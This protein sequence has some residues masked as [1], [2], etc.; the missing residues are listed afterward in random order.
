MGVHLGAL[1]S[2]R[3]IQQ[4]MVR[5]VC[6]VSGGT[7]GH[8]MPALVLARELRARGHDPVLMTEGREVERA[9]VERELPDMP[10]LSLP[11]TG[12]MQ[13]PS[14]LSMP[15]WVART[16]LAARRVLRNERIDCV[17]STGGR[18]SVPVGLAARSLGVPLFLLEQNAVTG[19]ANRLLSPLAKR[20]YHGLPTAEAGQRGLLTGTPLRP[21]VGRPERDQARRS[22]AFVTDAPL[23]LVVGG[24]Q[25]AQALNLV[26]PDAIVATERPTAV[27]HLAG[28]GKET[29]VVLRYITTGDRIEARVLPGTSDMAKLYA[30]ADLVI[31]RGGGT[32][33]AELIAAG[34]PAVIVPYPHH[35]DR[36]QVHNAEVLLAADAAVV[37]EEPQLRAPMLADILKLLLANPARMAAMGRAANAIGH[38]DATAAI[39]DDLEQT[40]GWTRSSR[41]PMSLSEVRE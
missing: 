15:W 18:A 28:A 39:V 38:G 29:A 12:A 31:C 16:T 3:A 37:V 33:V 34:R 20:I 8:L 1:P 6:L 30:A 24:S 5:R 4:A 41:R 13:R 19:R 40:N 21:E 14:R 35:S 26:V 11:R 7:G 22:L 2:T 25:G 9:M 32:T 36:Q 10:A 23:I 17:V 27:V